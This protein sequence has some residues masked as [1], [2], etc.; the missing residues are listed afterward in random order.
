M[1]QQTRSNLVVGVL[2]VLV[3]ALLLAG[4]Y[5][6]GLRELLDID[7]AWPLIVV[8]VGVF[9]FLLGLL[10]G[11]PGL[12][13]PAC[14]VAGVGGILYY[15]NATGDWTSWSYLWTLIPGFVG[16]GI[17]ISGLLSGQ[18]RT[19]LREGLSTILTSAVLF[20]IFWLFLGGSAIGWQYW[21]ILLIIFGLWILVRQLF[22][23][24]TTKDIT[25]T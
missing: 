16:V 7:F 19:S 3:G 10:T 20:V 25:G 8:A 6:P 21:P 14:I 13:V 15:Q 5:I 17:I 2:L 11:A 9:L 18:W 24:R 22:R 23:R 4:R 12:S 1:N